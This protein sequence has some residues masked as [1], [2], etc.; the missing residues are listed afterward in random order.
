LSAAIAISACTPFHPGAERSSN[1]YYVVQPGD[2]F[3]SIAFLFETTPRQLQRANPWANSGK[4]KAGMRLSVPR[5]VPGNGFAANEPDN[6]GHPAYTPDD[7]QI[8]SAGYIWP[9]VR[10]EVSSN[11]GHRRGRPHNGIDLRAPRGTPI[12]AAAGGRVIFSGYS[13]DYGQMVVIDHGQGV[14]TAYAHNSRNLVQRGQ[15]VSQGEVIARVGRSG[16]ATGYHLH[17]EFRRHGRALNPAH[18]LQAAM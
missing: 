14:E 15:R 3:H 1:R 5:S 12:H 13:G 16:N 17:F 9:L 10:F 2:N 4:L 7:I 18:Q 8:R 11:F 6:H